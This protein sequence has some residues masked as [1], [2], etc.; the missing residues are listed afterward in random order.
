MSIYCTYL[1]TYR[2]SK[3][4]P[5]YIGS[6]SI[7][8]LKDG[9]KG[10]VSS[11]KYKNI[12]ISELTENSH[13]FFTRIL[14]IHT[15]RKS[16]TVREFE[17]QKA[18]S[19][20]TNEL[21]INMAYAAKNYMYGQKQTP[22]HIKKR[23]FHR[24]G[25]IRSPQSA[26]TIEKRVSKLRGRTK[27]PMSQ[28]QKDKISLTKTG[29]KDSEMTRRKKSESA[30]GNPKPWLVGVSQTQEHIEKCNIARKID[31]DSWSEEKKAEFGRKISER[32]KGVPKG[33][34]PRV[35]L[36]N[37]TKIFCRISDRKEFSKPSFCRIFKD[38]KEY[39]W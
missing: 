20:V 9:Y 39:L 15:D 27:C 25:E 33:L 35:S 6:T 22:E 13:L 12:W 10:S 21:Y 5:F 30:R 37:S 4:P 31:R 3:L 23:T 16:A 38:L 28:T 17:I 14:T 19:V 26:E 18:M 36:L 29:V 2:G 34:S 1:T 8:K 7:K 32:T 24:R 11:T